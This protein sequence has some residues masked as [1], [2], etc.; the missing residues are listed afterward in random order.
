M[1][2]IPFAFV[3]ALWALFVAGVASAQTA[4]LSA[5]ELADPAKREAINEMVARMSEG[6]DPAS[7]TPAERDTIAAAATAAAQPEAKA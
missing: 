6:K 3:V 5:S 1:I 7:L 4:D 2:R